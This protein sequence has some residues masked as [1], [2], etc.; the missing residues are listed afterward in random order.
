MYDP[1]PKPVPFHLS[2]A[3][4][5]IGALVGGITARK[6]KEEVEKLND[7]LR[8]INTQLRMQARAGTMYAPGLTYAPPTARVGS[9][10][11]CCDGCAAV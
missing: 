8:S 7:Q 10:G 2:E 5:L 3:I 1:L 6:R 9:G 11:T 4:A